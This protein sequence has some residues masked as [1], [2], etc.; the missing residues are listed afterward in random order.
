MATLRVPRLV[1]ADLDGISRE[2]LLGIAG[3]LI[4][5][6]ELDPSTSGCGWRMVTVWVTCMVV[7][8]SRVERSA[9]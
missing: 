8:S 9:V 7:G 6:L 2:L 3:A 4:A 1:A 5:V